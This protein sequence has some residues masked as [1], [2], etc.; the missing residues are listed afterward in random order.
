[1]TKLTNERNDGL[2]SMSP[3]DDETIDAVMT[4]PS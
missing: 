2:R 4:V 1:M 3:L